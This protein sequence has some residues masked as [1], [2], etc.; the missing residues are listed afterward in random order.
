MSLHADGPVIPDFGSTSSC[1]KNNGL[2]CWDWFSQRWS[3]TF[4]PAIWQHIELTAIAV[5]VG[6]VIAFALAVL[7][8]RARWLIP[9]VTFVTSLLY[10]V[11]SLAAFEILVPIV[12]IN[13]WTVEIPL[14]SYT[15]LV[16][17]TN[18]LAGLSA[19]SGDV[20]DAAAGLGLTRMQTLWRV[21]LPLAVPTIIAGVRI[22]VVTIISLATVAAYVLPEGLGKV[23]FD[24]LGGGDFNTAFIAAGTLCV[25]LAL[26]ADGLFAVLQRVLT[27]WAAARRIA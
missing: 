25:L 24:A 6:F 2:F 3:N 14:V 5:G 11:P 8:Y 7:A 15:L 1:V 16:L 27:P 23:I 22:A 13:Y 9:P 19:V 17:F 18:V 12:G 20:R 10:T 21:E 26:L 4:V